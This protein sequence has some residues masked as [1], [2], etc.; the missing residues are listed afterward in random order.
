[1][2]EGS[3][4]KLEMVR[5]CKIWIWRFFNSWKGIFCFQRLDRFATTASL[6]TWDFRGW[7]LC[8]FFS[9]LQGISTNSM[10]SKRWT[11]R[12]RRKWRNNKRLLTHNVSEKVTLLRDRQKTATR[13]IIC[14]KKGSSNYET[15]FFLAG[16]SCKALDVLLD[17]EQWLPLSGRHSWIL[18]AF[19]SFEPWSLTGFNG[20]AD[21]GGQNQC[22]F[23]LWVFQLCV[24]GEQQTKNSCT[25]TWHLYTFSNTKTFSAAGQRHSAARTCLLQ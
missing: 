24:V 23:R 14:C 25:Y 11:R 22:R 12:K 10:F 7:C 5:S 3:H 15:V 6:P 2:F 1:M 4:R 16:F 20:A 13:R 19:S 21:S 8:R 18:Q 9:F 17:S